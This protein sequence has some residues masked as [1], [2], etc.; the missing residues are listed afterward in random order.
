MVDSD[1]SQRKDEGKSVFADV[2]WLN[3][4]S[5]SPD[6]TRCE[7]KLISNSLRGGFNAK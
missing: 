6:S 5:Y 1:V 7:D 4:A 3:N 2:E